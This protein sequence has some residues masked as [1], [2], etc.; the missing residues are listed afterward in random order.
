V[1]GKGTPNRA[2]LHHAKRTIL[3]QP[4]QKETLHDATEADFETKNGRQKKKKKCS[5][6][7]PSQRN[8]RMGRTWYAVDQAAIALA[9]SM[10]QQSPHKEPQRNDKSRSTL[11]GHPG[12]VDPEISKV[13]Q[14][15]PFRVGMGEET[16]THQANFKSKQGKQLHSTKISKTHL[17]DSVSSL[18]LYLFRPDDTMTCASSFRRTIRS[19][20][21]I[22]L[23]TCCFDT[24]MNMRSRRYSRYQGDGPN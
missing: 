12:A 14:W 21:T 1:C 3:K 19:Q 10:W 6:R 22:V 16:R 24:K 2:K 20:R 13:D 7:L 18:N 23:F 8:M 11:P 4:G 15:H 17:K 9:C 5:W